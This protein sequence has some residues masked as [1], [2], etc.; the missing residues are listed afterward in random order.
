MLNDFD[1]DVMQKKR[2]VA[3]ARHRVCGSKSR[4]CTLPSDMLTAAQ[5]RRR[6][7]PVNTYKL[8]APMTWEQFMSMPKDLQQ[9]YLTDL[10]DL[11]QATDG[12]LG[13]MFHVHPI[14]IGKHRNELGVAPLAK[15]L[16]SKGKAMAEARWEA[17][18]NGVVGGDSTED[19]ETKKDTVETGTAEPAIQESPSPEIP[20]KNKTESPEKTLNLD[21]IRATFSGQFDA[22]KF[23]NWISKLPIPDGGV[24][25][26]VEVSSL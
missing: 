10:R 25:I 11:Y 4:R 24:R 2:L 6:N 15:R 8:D 22:E 14:T 18:C 21:G 3:S 7:G 13:Q 12:M 23:L 17:F 5:L 16:S 1:Y 26:S 19:L 9:K 20:S